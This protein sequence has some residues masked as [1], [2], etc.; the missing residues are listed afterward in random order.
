MVAVILDTT[1]LVAYARFDVAVGELIF[2]VDEDGNS[3]GIPALCVLAAHDELGPD[4]RQWLDR[5]LSRTDGPSIVT[6][7]LLGEDSWP[8]AASGKR[9]DVAHAYAEARRHDVP[10]A[11][12][13]A[14][15]ARRE[16]DFDDVLDLGEP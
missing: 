7:P 12:F 14:T 13:A 15:E 3:I 10:L 6:L 16:F 8:V 4:D 11:T 1:A 9:H 2:M 5:L